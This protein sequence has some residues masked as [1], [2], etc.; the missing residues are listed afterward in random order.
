MQHK[1]IKK[2]TILLTIELNNDNNK[3]NMFNNHNENNDYSNSKISNGNLESIR[4][5]TLW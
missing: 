3:N 4:L 1:Y 5:L 2:I